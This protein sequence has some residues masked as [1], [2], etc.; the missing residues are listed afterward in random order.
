MMAAPSLPVDAA[1]GPCGGCPPPD[2]F[3]IARKACLVCEIALTRS[4]TQ[5][6]YRGNVQKEQGHAEARLPATLAPCAPF[7]HPHAFVRERP[8]ETCIVRAWTRA[9]FAGTRGESP[10]CEG[11]R[12]LAR[13]P[14]AT[15]SGSARP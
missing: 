13:L 6:R 8:W 5:G 11:G 3:S 14:R 2:G 12:A 15:I 9:R 4:H 1:T 10:Q 7:G